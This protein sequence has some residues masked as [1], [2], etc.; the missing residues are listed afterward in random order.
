MNKI[1]ALI[2]QLCPNGV[3]FRTLGEVCEVLR[4][5]RLTKKELK[6]DGKYPVFHGGLIPLGRY[7]K[8]NRKANQTMVI[9][10]GSVGEVV[11]SDVDFWS[12]DGTFVVETPDNINDRYLYFFLKTQEPYLKTQKREGGVPTID[13]VAVE[14]LQIPL[15][16]LAVQ[17]EIVNILD[18]FTKLEA[19]LEAELKA[20][21]KQYEY[22]RCKLLTFSEI[23]MG[24]GGQMDYK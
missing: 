22:Y 15:P 4:G 10:T 5:K 17:Q 23:L 11:W 16:P 2:N 7:D 21:K 9:N 18:K 3:E 13:R 12:S 24:G 8:Y 14:K 1:Q 19:E 6:D 20:R